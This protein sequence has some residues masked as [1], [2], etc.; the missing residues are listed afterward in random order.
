MNLFRNTSFIIYDSTE[1]EEGCAQADKG[2]SGPCNV[3]VTP[4]FPLWSAYQ[5]GR[6]QWVI[7]K[8]LLRRME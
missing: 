3:E 4:N 5:K 2:H 7:K 6:G 1:V 8:I